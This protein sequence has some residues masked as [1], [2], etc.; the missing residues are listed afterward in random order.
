MLFMLWQVIKS[1]HVVISGKIS[2]SS[3]HLKKEFCII[4]DFWNSKLENGR[5]KNGKKV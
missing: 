2:K 4:L 3:L 5:I 1:L